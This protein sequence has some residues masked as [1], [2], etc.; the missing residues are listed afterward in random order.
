MRLPFCLKC[1]GGAYFFDATKFLH[2][3]ACCMLLLL[4]VLI[5]VL[6][7]AH[8]M[9][10]HLVD[11]LL[12]IEMFG[13]KGQHACVSSCGR[14]CECES[15]LFCC[16]CLLCFLLQCLLPLWLAAI[17]GGARCLPFVSAKLLIWPAKLLSFYG[18]LKLFLK[19]FLWF[20]FSFWV[21]NNICYF[22]Y[23]IDN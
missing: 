14:G 4:L 17:H 5:S 3:F 1:P 6:L 21:Y 10:A 12:A 7:Q 11:I 13:S 9:R 18:C 8:I 15:S 20:F 2:L 16:F 22:F 19:K 23:S